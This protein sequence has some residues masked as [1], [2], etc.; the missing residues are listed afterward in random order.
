[1]ISKVLTRTAPLVSRAAIGWAIWLGG[2]AVVLFA[3]LARLQAISPWGLLVCLSLLAALGGLLLARTLSSWVAAS[4]VTAEIFA[5]GVMGTSVI[6]GL[7]V[8]ALQEIAAHEAWAPAAAQWAL[9]LSAGAGMLA[10]LDRLVPHRHAPVAGQ[11]RTALLFLFAL[12]L[13]NVPEGLA[14]SMSEVMGPT[15]A[16]GIAIQNVPESV[17]AMWLLTAAGWSA[18]RAGA[19]GFAAV[20][21][22]PAVAL[23][24]KSLGL[25]V[26]EHAVLMAGL[27]AGAMGFVLIHEFAPRLRRVGVRAML[28]LASGSALVLGLS[29]WM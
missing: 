26:A 7:I 16:L 23:L 12:A 21:V 6:V 13:H 1:M 29:A 17:L 19:W 10:L 22:E 24:A 14:L 18:A 2:A 8:P 25:A 11:D 4:P 15:L 27:A 28:P 5:A 9:A 20:S 3:S